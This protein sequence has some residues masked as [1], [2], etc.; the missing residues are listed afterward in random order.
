MIVIPFYSIL[1]AL[2][3]IKRFCKM[4]LQTG[5]LSL[6]QGRGLSFWFM[7]EPLLQNKNVKLS[8]RICGLPIDQKTL[9]SD[10]ET[11]KAKIRQLIHYFTSSN[12]L[13]FG[14]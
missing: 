10:K 9:I 11:F 4:Y 12:I 13:N 5:H 1:I 7:W 6:N 3:N 2:I 14:S 8:S